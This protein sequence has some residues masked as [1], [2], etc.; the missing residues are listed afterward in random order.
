MYRY[1]YQGARYSSSTSSSI[2]TTLSECGS[3]LAVARSIR[4]SIFQSHISTTA[5]NIPLL[6]SQY[7][8]SPMPQTPPLATTNSSTIQ[9]PPNH[10][11]RP[12]SS[13]HFRTWIH[14]NSG[15]QGQPLR[16]YTTTQHKH[17]HDQNTKDDGAADGKDDVV[18]RMKQLASSHSNSFGTNKPNA[19]SS[20]D[21][22]SHSHSHGHLHIHSHGSD[23]MSAVIDLIRHKKAGSRITLI[24]MGANVGLTALKGFAGI[25]F[26]SASL[27]ADAMHSFSDIL[28]DIVTFYTFKK[29]RQSADITHPYGYGR[30]EAIGTLI[31]SLFLVSAGVGVGFH[32]LE[33]LVALIPESM[34]WIT[35]FLNDTAS[36]N[37]TT[38]VSQSVETTASANLQHIPTSESILGSAATTAGSDG[39]DQHNIAASSISEQGVDPKAIWFAGSSIVI[40][41][42]LFHATMKVGKRA[43]SDVLIANAWHHRSDALTSFVAMGAIVGSIYGM[44]ILDPLGGLVVSILLAKSGGEMA[45]NALQELTDTLHRPELQTRL[46]DSLDVYTD[47]DRNLVGTSSVRSRKSGPFENVDLVVH[48]DPNTQARDIQKSVDNLKVYLKTKFKNIREVQVNI[49]ALPI[50]TKTNQTIQK[51]ALEDND[52][53]QKQQQ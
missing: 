37:S 6:L 13:T 32:S 46:E 31:V 26:H 28:G 45:F 14:N 18:E 23:E 41:E 36:T 33:G 4:H 42:A 44:P 9:C 30:Y 38:G 19:S 40:N 48:V 39:F 53:Y 47:S 17:G 24:G 25:Y 20:H 3:G 21:E 11:R 16:K 35:S 22:H 5:S 2:V 29:A 12:Y 49:S 34:G 8:S 43:N 27:L 10:A 7:T 1:C 51:K 15:L 50:K 52:Q